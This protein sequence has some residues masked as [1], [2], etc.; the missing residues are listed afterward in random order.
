MNTFKCIT[1]VLVF[2]LISVSNAQN[3]DTLAFNN[4]LKGGRWALQ[5]EL[6]TYINPSYFKSVELSIKPQLSRSTALRLGLGFNLNNSSGE[7][8]VA[9]FTG[10]VGSKYTD[11]GLSL[12]SNNK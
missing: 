1:L 2:G 9:V 12:K 6:G 3:K 11:L 5:F 8:D 10:P 4:Y 7:A